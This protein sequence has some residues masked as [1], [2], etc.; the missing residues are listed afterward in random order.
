VAS[1]DVHIT[2]P[3]MGLFELGHLLGF[4]PFRV[5]QSPRLQMTV[6]TEGLLCH[7]AGENRESFVTTVGWLPDPQQSTTKSGHPALIAETFI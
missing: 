6:K 7:G 5:L 4:R 2:K 1:S 3:F